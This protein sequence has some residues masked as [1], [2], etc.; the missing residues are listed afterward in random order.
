MVNPSR[1]SLMESK[2]SCTINSTLHDKVPFL[3]HWFFSYREETFLFCTSIL[4][5]LHQLELN[6]IEKY[7]NVSPT[8][9]ST[10]HHKCLRYRTVAKKFS[11]SPL[12]LSFCV[13]GIFPFFSFSVLNCLFFANRIVGTKSYTLGDVYT[14]I[15]RIETKI[16]NRTREKRRKIR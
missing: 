11:I 10:I 3:K 9:H 4:N 14:H 16:K 1:E 7:I 5:K 13:A 15:E 8:F 6:S 12:K 2:L